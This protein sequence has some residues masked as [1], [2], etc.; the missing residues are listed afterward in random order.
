MIKA[1]IASFSTLLLMHINLPYKSTIL[2]YVMGHSNDMTKAE[3]VLSYPPGITVVL[4]E[5][6]TM[7]DFILY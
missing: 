7:L 5:V 2:S 3:G 6:W 4:E 1:G